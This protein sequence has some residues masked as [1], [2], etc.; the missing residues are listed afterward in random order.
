MMRGAMPSSRRTSLSAIAAS[1]A[2]GACALAPGR[3]LDDL[4]LPAATTQVLLSTTADWPATAAS[5]QRFART[6]DGWQAVGAPIAARVGRSGLAWGL[7]RHKDGDGPQKREGD[8]CAPAG[9]FTIGP[10]FGYAAAVP[11]GWSIA[12]REA[13]A[14][15][16]FVDD[17]ASR[18]YNTWQRIPDDQ[19]DD[20]AA[21]WRSCERMRRSDAQYEF[22]M[23]VGHNE[24][25]VQGRG[26]AIFLHVWHGPDEPT[27]GCT[28]MARGDLLTVLGWLCDAKAPLLVQVPN[29][30]LSR[31]R[32]HT[33]AAA[34]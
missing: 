6:A 30:E 13:T 28:A 21:R 9:V 19:P 23:V 7:G 32:L 17:V 25:C 24:A 34:R 31:L 4:A 3:A 33:A 10:A 18:D 8:G 20:A 11:A 27:S 14:R 15:D 16:Y 12:Y 26:S 1:T 22:G 5:V 2:L 29:R